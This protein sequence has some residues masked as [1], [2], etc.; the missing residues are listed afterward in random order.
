MTRWIVATLIALACMVDVPA[1][2]AP[3]EN[4]DPSLAPWYQGL[5]QP[6]T[7]VSCCS[8]ADCR[9][10]EDRVGPNGYE[11]LLE[12]EWRPVPP[13]K[14]LQGK[15][16]PTGRAVVCSSPALGILCFV[17]AR[18]H[19]KAGNYSGKAGLNCW[20][21]SILRVLDMEGVTGS[22]PV[23]PTTLSI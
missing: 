14:I 21:A 6:D 19:D 16:N 17:R 4:A 13:E 15:F 9:P 20:P 3:P 7:G 11:V 22:I 5:Q 23:V 2:P 8:I 10:V 12:D 18:R 1:W